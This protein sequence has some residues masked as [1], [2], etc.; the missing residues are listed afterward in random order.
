[1]I[2]KQLGHFEIQAKIGEGGMGAVYRARDLHLGRTVALKVLPP[3]MTSVPERKAR[4]IQ[5]AKAASSLQHPNIVTIHEFGSEGGVD[6]IAM[7]LVEGRTL[8]ALIPRGGMNQVEVAKIAVQLADGLAKAHAAKIVHR[9]L[10]PSNVM[11]SADGLAKILDF[12]LAKLLETAPISHDA[13]TITNVKTQDGAIMGTVSY[14]SPEQ[15][16]GLALD[17]RSDI[18]SFGS[19][20]YE[21][22]TGR[23]A[24][25][26]ETPT[27]T[28]AAVMRD[29]ADLS[30]LPP[31]FQGV[32]S[33]CLE[34]NLDR[35][36]QTMADVRAAL[37]SAEVTGAT[38]P[39]AAPPLPPGRRRWRLAGGAVLAAAAMLG[40]ALWLRRAP[41]EP[42]AAMRVIPLTSDPGFERAPTFSP[43][44]NQVAFT[45]D[46]GKREGFHLYAKMVGGPTALQLTTKPGV[47]YPAWSPDGKLIAFLAARD[48][49][50]GLYLISPLGGPE[51]RLGGFRGH[52]QLTWS[53]DSKFLAAAVEFAEVSPPADAG[54]IMLIPVDGGGTPR[55]LLATAKGKWYKDPDFHP[56]SRTLAF[57]ACDGSAM[58]PR[59]QIQVVG[60][61]SNWAPSGAAR[62]L[63][64]QIQQLASPRWTP[65]GDALVYSTS[66]HLWRVGVNGGEPLRLDVAG[67]ATE[68]PASARRGHRLAFQHNM[69]NLDV[70]RMDESGACQPLIAS[71]LRDISA[72]FSPDGS[73]IAFVTQ[74]G[75]ENLEIWVAN[76]DGSAQTPLT[77]GP[78][79][80][81]GTPAWSP[82]GKWIA[83]DSQ[84]GDSAIRQIW[85]IESAG[86]TARQLTSLPN[87]ANVPAWSRDGLSIYFNSDVTGRFEIYRMPVKGGTPEQV[88]QA[89]GYVAQ[90][91]PDGKTLY[92]IKS[93]GESPLY[94]M[95]VSGGGTEAKV[96]DLVA[97]RGFQVFPDGVYFLGV[98]NRQLEV[99]FRPFAAGAK[100]RSI[101]PV[102]AKVVNV[103]MSVS[104]DRKSILLNYSP[105]SGS[106]LMLIENFR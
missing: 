82:D 93:S 81:Q 11:V 92:Y 97:G 18:F 9:D 73:R 4:L 84:S 64:R 28:M 76:A 15:A 16:E 40:A 70:W 39:A 102:K 20:L 100:E 90:E 49:Q 88:T 66:D 101:G 35:R 65:E 29:S 85:M 48:G 83:F 69:A 67:V 17:A 3:A 13:A 80:V 46:G 59:C 5:E 25:Q 61:D 32:V 103:Y 24:F 68:S 45:A 75:G 38:M 98:V 23:R 41:E 79:I 91:S 77:S 2:G 21:M 71:S 22:L 54:A 8:A 37:L 62:P 78:G 87:G 50:T 47:M 34:K 30:I 105:Q 14:M 43:D 72:R 56:A 42:L 53:F 95:P 1:M 58:N 7:E 31:K 63:T 60:L 44:G 52:G 99:R 36:F 27:G 106:D 26:R 104:P 74:R 89:G 12:G 33:R 19:M 55:V 57:V 10:K 51:R 96:L 86:G 6:F 94:A